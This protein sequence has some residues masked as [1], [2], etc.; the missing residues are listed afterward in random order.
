MQI[1]IKLMS[2][3]ELYDINI[4]KS[5]GEFIYNGINIKCN[6]EEFA[7]K[8]CNIVIFWDENMIVPNVL[9]AESFEVNIIKDGKSYNFKGNGKYPKNYTAFKKLLKEYCKC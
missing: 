6:I 3:Y 9:G 8:L 7:E 2:K 1:Q 4:N 5:T